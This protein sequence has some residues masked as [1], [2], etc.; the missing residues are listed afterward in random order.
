MVNLA[1]IGF[2]LV[3]LVWL[4]ADFPGL[5]DFPELAGLAVDFFFSFWAGSGV[6][7]PAGFWAETL[8]ERSGMERTEETKRIDKQRLRIAD[9]G[10]RIE[11]I[12]QFGSS[13]FAV[14][15]CRLGFKKSA[16]RNP[17][18]SILDPRSSI[19]N[20]RSFVYLAS[21]AQRNPVLS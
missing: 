19:L 1:L 18:S 8:C 13:R 14:S 11:G 5:A 15:D 6:S 4:G 20:P 2:D 7:R 12:L 9:C 21:R 10:L 3:A 17:Q 16:I